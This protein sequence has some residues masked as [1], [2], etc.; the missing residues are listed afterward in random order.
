MDTNLVSISIEVGLLNRIRLFLNGAIINVKAELSELEF[1][2]GALRQQHHLLPEPS[3]P[4][5][6]LL[7][8]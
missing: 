3:G 1:A 2:A 6:M 5:K 8:T 7:T 4:L